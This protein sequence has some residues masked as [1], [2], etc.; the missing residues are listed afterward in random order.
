[1]Y[2]FGSVAGLILLKG[3]APVEAVGPTIGSIII[4]AAFGFASEALGD[5]LTKKR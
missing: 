1:M 3:L 5:V 4:G 2:G